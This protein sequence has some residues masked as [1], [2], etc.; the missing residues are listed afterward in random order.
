ME[1][2]DEELFVDM[3]KLLAGHEEAG[4]DRMQELNERF[5]NQ[6]KKDSHRPMRDFV[7]EQTEGAFNGLDRRLHVALFEGELTEFALDL[8]LGNVSRRQGARG[9]GHPRRIFIPAAQH[10]HI[11]QALGNPVANGSVGG[12]AALGN[13]ILLF[14]DFQGMV[15]SGEFSRREGIRQCAL[16]HS[17]R[18]EVIRQFKHA[19]GRLGFE[20]NRG[21]QM[22]FAAIVFGQTI[23]QGLAE[24]VVDEDTPAIRRFGPDNVPLLRLMQRGNGLLRSLLRQ[25]RR[26]E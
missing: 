9:R 8:R 2:D 6:V 3:F 26:G 4:Q 12:C 1:A 24:L 7:T 16:A 13:V 17:P 11:A 21:V 18:V 14:G 10:E 20:I 15:G 25:L 23:E 19:I 5:P 22:Q